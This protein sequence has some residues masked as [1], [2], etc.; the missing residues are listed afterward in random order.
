MAA[1]LLSILGAANAA[2]LGNLVASSSLGEPFRAE[3]DLMAYGDE[4]ASLTPRMA[5]PDAYQLAGYRYNPALAG[6]RLIA[7]KHPNG[8]GYIEL[9]SSRPVNE[10]FLYLLIQL[11]SN[12]TRI[13]R[14][15]TVFIDPPDSGRRSCRHR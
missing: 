8:R 3:I 9:T 10:P 11:D 2:G 7:R 13:M 5:P 15:Y 14:G 1:L 6:A 4:W 12:A